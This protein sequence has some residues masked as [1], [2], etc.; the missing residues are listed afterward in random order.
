MRLC[1]RVC[2]C[3]RV[4]ACVCGC[5]IS[6]GQGLD[7]PRM[8]P[9]TPAPTTSTP[10]F[11]H[12]LAPQPAPAFPP[13][14]RPHRPARHLPAQHVTFPPS[15]R[16][17]RPGQRPSCLLQ[18]LGSQGPVSALRLAASQT[19][20]CRGRR[21]GAVGRR[22]PLPLSSIPVPTHR[23]ASPPQH[24]PPAP[25]PRPVRAPSAPRL[26]PR[27]VGGTRHAGPAAPCRRRPGR[28]PWGAVAEGVPRRLVGVP[29]FSAHDIRQVPHAVADFCGTRTFRRLHGNCARQVT[30]WV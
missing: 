29:R 9:W 7:L 15:R 14:R 23:Q 6:H 18:R 13:S 19:W 1:T 16:P 5:E 21:G 11:V 22:K 17:H 24:V 27:R 10:A 12:L 2:L 28:S 4:C 26:H 3:M 30:L 25:R 20:A 8:S